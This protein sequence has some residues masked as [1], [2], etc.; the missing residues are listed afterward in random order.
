MVVHLEHLDVLR[1]LGALG[2][3]GIR[4]CRVSLRGGIV[5]ASNHP[6]AC[7]IRV[8]RAPGPTRTKYLVQVRYVPT[9]VSCPGLRFCY[10]TVLLV[11]LLYRTYCTCAVVFLYTHRERRPPRARIRALF[12]DRVGAREPHTSALS[13]FVA[14]LFPYDGVSHRTAVTAP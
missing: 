7:L 2:V 10:T 1:A 12:L 8:C 5:R 4:Y 6:F 13:F 11:H 9:T 14:L 3:Q